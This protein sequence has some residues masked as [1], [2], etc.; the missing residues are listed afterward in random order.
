M[1]CTDTR[2]LLHPYIDGELDLVRSLDVEKHIEAC[3]GCAAE[4]KSLRS[5][6]SVLHSQ[7]L[8]YSAPQSLKN[9]TSEIAKPP[10]PETHPPRLPWF[11][12]WWAFGATALAAL[13]L[14]MRPAGNGAGDLL[15]N[16]MVSN[17]V[18]SLMAAHLTDVVSSDQHTVKPWFNGKLDFAPGVKDFSAEGFPL[19]GGRLDYL[20]DHEVAALIYR[21]NK[22]VINVFVWP[23]NQ[24]GPKFSGNKSLHGYNLVG[25]DVSGL[26]YALVSDLN[27]S[28]LDQLAD[29]IG[30]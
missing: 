22:H 28:E 24:S 13:L 10:K 9:S 17:H 27:A 16:E 12:Q 1:N 29:L 14:I 8:T 11:W 25:R 15:A 6:R 26:H 21:R 7:S 5:L 23:I 18:R 4:N 3:S 19:V 30:K 20:S 2:Q